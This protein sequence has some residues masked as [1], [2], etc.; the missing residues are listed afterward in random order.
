VGERREIRAAGLPVS[1][2]PLSQAIAAGQFV[3]V[4]GQVP[5]DPETGLV[6]EDIEAQTHQVLRN[7]ETVL[8]AAG[9]RLDQVV[10]VA[11]H[12]ADLA[13]RPGFNAAYR[14]H[15]HEPFPARTTVGSQLEGILVEVDVVAFNP[16][17]DG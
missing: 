11:A 5:R 17:I 14:E 12:L 10:K 7:I 3:F 15:F 2:A 9:C 16:D 13:L 8:A 1:A 4:S 6:A